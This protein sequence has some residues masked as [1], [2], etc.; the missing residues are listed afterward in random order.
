[1]SETNEAYRKFKLVFHSIILI[2]AICL[3]VVGFQEF[4]RALLYLILG[5]LFAI[6]SLYSLY[7]NIREN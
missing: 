5:I 3:I 7:K 4:D 6:Q 1:M 2:I